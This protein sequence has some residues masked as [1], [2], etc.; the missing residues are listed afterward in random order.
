[1]PHV[2]AHHDEAGGNSHV[3]VALSK[4]CLLAGLAIRVRKQHMREVGGEIVSAIEE[5]FALHCRASKLPEPVR[6]HRFAPPRRWRMDFAWE[7]LKIAAEIEGGIW[8]GGRHTRGS[9]FESDAE[10]YNAAALMGWKVFRF[11]GGMVK[12]GAAIETIKEALRGNHG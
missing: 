7:N 11:T 6:E 2:Q 8:T 5:M 3:Q 12:S 9:G 10:K 1:M 4:L